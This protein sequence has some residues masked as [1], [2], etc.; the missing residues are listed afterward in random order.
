[1]SRDKLEEIE[2]LIAEYNSESHI[3]NKLIKIRVVSEPIGSSG[4]TGFTGPI[5]NTKG[6]FCVII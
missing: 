1:M 2:R 4:Q 6:M 3:S 5:G